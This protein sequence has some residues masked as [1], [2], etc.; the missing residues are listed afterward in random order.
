MVGHRL[1]RLRASDSR[2][3]QDFLVGAA[4]VCFD[5]RFDLR[6]TEL[7]M[8]FTLIGTDRPVWQSGFD[9]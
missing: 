5:C 3:E 4:D 8:P 6:G 1:S 7:L 9:I 2:K